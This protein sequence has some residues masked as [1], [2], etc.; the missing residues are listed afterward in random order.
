MNFY[1]SV[2]KSSQGHWVALCLENGIVGQGKTKNEALAKL[3][4]AVDSFEAARKEEPDIYSASVSIKE[5]HEFLTFEEKEFITEPLE[6]RA[7]Y[8]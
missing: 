4:E 2:L 3:K 8:A 1:T 6:L 7:M 5:L